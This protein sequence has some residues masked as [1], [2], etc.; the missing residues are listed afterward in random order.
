MSLAENLQVGWASVAYY[1]WTNNNTALT[2]APIP[3]TTVM[4]TI[5]NVDSQTITAPGAVTTI[6][7]QGKGETVIVHD[8]NAPNSFVQFATLSRWTETIMAS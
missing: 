6:T 7:N 1:F 3:P 5:T 4:Q 8:P 2:A